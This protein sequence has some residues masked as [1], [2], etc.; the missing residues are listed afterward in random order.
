[1]TQLIAVLRLGE[2]RAVDF[3]TSLLDALKLPKA[4]LVG[5]SMGG[6]WAIAFALAAPVAYAMS[7][8]VLLPA[9]S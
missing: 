4:A 9:L 6:Y 5:N 8:M 3:V 2:P 7:V 1:M